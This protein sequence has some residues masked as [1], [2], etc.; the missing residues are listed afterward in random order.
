MKFFSI[1]FTLH[2]ALLPAFGGEEDL[3]NLFKG[4][5]T[6]KI[7]F[8]QK[9]VLPVAGDEVT[10]YQGVIYYKRPLKFRWEYTKGANVLILSDGKFLKSEIEGECQVGELSSQP[11]F[12]LIELIEDP[13]K[14]RRD[15]EVERV[16]KKGDLEVIT[17]VP[18]YEGA[19]FKKISFILDGGRLV[20]VETLQEDGTKADYQI[21]EIVKNLPLDDSLFQLIPC[22]E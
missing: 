10:L 21:E 20:G 18:K 8:S 15:F 9:T 16:E 1:L 5:N 3:Y 6:L 17:I 19:F 13:Q 2:L 12:P 14:F 22:R 7:V 4:V 11:L